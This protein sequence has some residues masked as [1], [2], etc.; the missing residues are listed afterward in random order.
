[1]QWLFDT[2]MGSPGLGGR[3]PAWLSILFHLSNAIMAI[4]LI[5]IPMI[6]VGMW[7]YR[8]DGFQAVRIWRILA[9]LPALGL[10]KSLRVQEIWGPPYHLTAIVDCVCAVVTTYSVCHLPAL[11]KHILLLPSRD[12]FRKMNEELRSILLEKEE[13]MPEL[14]DRYR[15]LRSEVDHLQGQF[16]HITWTEAAIRS[17][18]EIRTLLVE[19]AA[20]KEGG[21]ERY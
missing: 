17:M 12:Q 11:F 4:S 10:S 16:E 7:S 2:T 20:C 9:F 6:V 19:P 8:R 14:T 13:E 18:T 1:M 3:W 21:D 15:T 5:A